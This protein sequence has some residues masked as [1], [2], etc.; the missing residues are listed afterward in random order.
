MVAKK[1]KEDT[2]CIVKCCKQK[3]FIFPLLSVCKRST[4]NQYHPMARLLLLHFHP[5]SSSRQR[6]SSSS[7]KWEWVLPGL[8]CS[9]PTLFPKTN[10]QGFLGFNF[11]SPGIRTQTFVFPLAALYSSPAAPPIVLLEG[12]LVLLFASCFDF[13]GL[14][15]DAAVSQAR[16]G[17]LPFPGQRRWEGKKTQYQLLS[18]NGLH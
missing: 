14:R 7:G 1:N 15:C 13:E 5:C 4:T 2:F 17:Y 9:C 16:D 11:V 18:G 3:R 8:C 6:E 12:C 10:S